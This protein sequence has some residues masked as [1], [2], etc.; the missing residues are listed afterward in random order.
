MVPGRVRRANHMP[1]HHRA[2]HAADGPPAG[3]G[4][5]RVS[6]HG[7]SFSAAVGDSLTLEPG[8]MGQE[9]TLLQPPAGTMGDQ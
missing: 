8:L 1:G 4:D 7:F 2:Q 3:A 5:Q 6:Q 9:R